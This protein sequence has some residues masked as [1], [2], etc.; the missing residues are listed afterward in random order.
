MLIPEEFELPEIKGHDVLIAAEWCGVN[1][2]DLDH[3]RQGKMCSNGVAYCPGLECSGS[4]IAV[5][6]YVHEH[7]P[8]D[9]VCAIL[10]GGGYADKVVVP[11]NQVFE[12]PDSISLKEAA[13]F[14]EAAC[15]IWQAFSK[16]KIQKGKTILI[17]ETCGYYAV[18]AIQ[19]ARL[20][21][22]EVFVATE[23][24][25]NNM[26]YMELGACKCINWK[27]ND[28]LAQVK[29][30]TSNKGG[31]EVILDNRRD[32]L[33]QDL[34][35]LCRGGVLVFLDL[36]GQRLVDVDIQCLMAKNAEIQ[37]LD[38]ARNLDRQ[39]VLGAKQ[40]MQDAIKTELV[41]LYP[42]KCFHLSEANLAHKYIESMNFGQKILSTLVPWSP[43]LAPFAYL[44]MLGKHVQGKTLLNCQVKGQLEGQP[45]KRQKLE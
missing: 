9:R 20:K 16:G 27:D 22:A 42:G 10:D 7:K 29:K 12:V 36:H 44:G 23:S 25:E 37:V 1:R 41:K 34:T 17:H 45:D 3:R 33:S 8:S 5:G 39:V 21:G 32:H 38:R 18:F 26:F 24:D 14:P 31:I 2:T 28:F 19:M 40:Y 13:C 35:T 43:G 30:L 11:A 6:E 4:I 15:T